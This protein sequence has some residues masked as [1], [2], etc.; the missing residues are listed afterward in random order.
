MDE[1]ATCIPHIWI[2]ADR[3]L[4][5]CWLYPHDDV[6]ASVRAKVGRSIPL[7]LNLWPHIDQPPGCS[8]DEL[9]LKIVAWAVSRFS[10]PQDAA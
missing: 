8:L 5:Q 10:E 4:K 3:E 9:A 1:S 6:A 7:P 2:V